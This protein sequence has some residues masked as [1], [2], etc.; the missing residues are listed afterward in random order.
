MSTDPK[1]YQLIV[2]K[3]L[4]ELSERFF[5]HKRS[6][7]NKSDNLETGWGGRRRTTINSTFITEKPTRVEMEREVNGILEDIL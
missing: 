5:I 3:V 1:E 4:D 2:T 7:I 6:T